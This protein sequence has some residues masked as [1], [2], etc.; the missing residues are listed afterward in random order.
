MSRRHWVIAILVA[1][2]YERKAGPGSTK[3]VVIPA[4]AKSAK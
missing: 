1:W 2:V 4:P 3:A